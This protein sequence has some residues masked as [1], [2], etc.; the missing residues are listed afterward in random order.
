MDRALFLLLEFTLFVSPLVFTDVFD[1][2]WEFP[3]QI[4]FAVLL[5][6]ALIILGLKYWKTQWVWKITSLDLAVTLFL[7]ATMFVSL[8]SQSPLRSVI[9]FYGV[10]APTL[11][12]SLVLVLWYGIV[13]W[14]QTVTNNL[15]LWHRAILGGTIF[16]FIYILKQILA[17]QR[18][19]KV[20]IFPTTISGNQASHAD[21]GIYLM[22]VILMG[23][24]YFQV[25]R[26][27]KWV[28][29]IIGL[30]IFGLLLT[31]S[32]NAW[33]GTILGLISL[34]I[35]QKVSLK[36]VLININKKPIFLWIT[37]F[38]VFVLIVSIFER[39][40]AFFIL[41]PNHNSFF[42]R[43]DELVAA[44]KI[45]LEYPLTGFG[46]GLAVNYL[47]YYR[48]TS[49]IN[50]IVDPNFSYFKVHSLFVELL[51]GGGIIQFAAFMLV[52][53]LAL[54]IIYQ[55]W[56]GKKIEPPVVGI[57]TVFLAILIVSL[58]AGYTF[59]SSIMLWFCLG[60]ISSWGKVVKSIILP[61]V[62]AT[63]MMIL[64]GASLILLCGRAAL[65]NIYYALALKSSPVFT[66]DQTEDNPRLT[67]QFFATAIKLDPFNPD[68]LR[69]S[70]IVSLGRVGEVLKQSKSIDPEKLPSYQETR[71]KLQQAFQLDPTSSE[72][73]R[74]LAELTFFQ[75]KFSRGDTVF[76]ETEDKA[77]R[78]V[79]MDP[80]NFN[81]WNLLGLIYLDQNKLNEAEK[82]FR[83]TVKLKADFNQGYYHLGETLK[84]MGRLEE[85]L[86][87][88]QETLKYAAIDDFYLQE[89]AKVKALQ[90]KSTIKLNQ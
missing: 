20:F 25:T 49:F 31:Y 71:Q 40:R 76:Q 69:A 39:V 34:L 14:Q 60:V 70:S 8:F 62:T 42:I 48:A 78:A 6:T 43:F 10:T 16:S 12:W 79:K 50:Q 88:Y 63:L 65:G 73:I 53:S 86:Q 89:V 80:Q 41:D 5:G 75:A 47:T 74:M 45:F 46:P 52:V 37:V 32:R 85:A 33:L 17:D 9:G 77:M 59:V 84:Q 36:K 38:A 55:H 58:S 4:V 3:K 82:A 61:R 26:F 81:N 29:L 67:E 18:L 54:K 11:I 64:L 72:T 1:S 2:Y 7:L 68:Y 90:N 19:P 15:N 28:G 57:I 13:R 21:L 22:V 44:T 23:I 27:K 66:K 30:A 35:L 56:L 51:S 24:A 83:Q 87:A